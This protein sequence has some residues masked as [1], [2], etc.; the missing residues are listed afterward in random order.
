[1]GDIEGA[2]ATI[3]DQSRYYQAITRNT[4]D[5]PKAV[6]WFP[7]KIQDLDRQSYNYTTRNNIQH[8]STQ[9]VCKPDPVLR[10]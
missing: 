3:Q 8:D 1:M 2:L 10:L 4:K 5:N 7:R 9:Q 6:P